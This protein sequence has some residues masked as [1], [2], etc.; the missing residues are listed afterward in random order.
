MEDEKNLDFE[1]NNEKY[2]I[3]KFF[4]VNIELK[5]TCFLKVNL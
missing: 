1:N 2:N 5:K 4:T 3:E